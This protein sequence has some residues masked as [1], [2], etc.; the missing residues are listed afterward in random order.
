M[1]TI[2][3]V[4]MLIPARAATGSKSKSLLCRS[5]LRQIMSAMMMYT[6]DNDNF[7]PPNPGDG[8]ATPGHNWCAGVARRGRAEEFNPDILRD[9]T[10]CLLTTY[11]KTN[12]SV[13][14]CTADTRLGL[15]TGADPAKQSTLVPVARSISMNQAVGTDPYPP[16]YGKLPVHGPWLDNAHGHT[17]YGP[18]RTY[19]KTSQVVAPIPAK[20]WVIIEEDSYSI[21][22]A[23]FGLG[24]SAAVWIDWPSTLHDMGGV[25]A[26]ADGHV[27]L[28]K[29]TDARTRVVS[30]MVAQ[31]QVPGNKDWLW[32]SERTSARAN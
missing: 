22:D 29:W 18:W 8:N 5:N 11:L 2:L 3:L 13:Y 17:R 25:A 4:A 1:A 28:H 21:N 30:D 9:P 26:F 6:Q 14:R 12:V 32:L 27:E 10:R 7:F 23:S 24:M 15:Y 16:S 20:L 19:G 31:K